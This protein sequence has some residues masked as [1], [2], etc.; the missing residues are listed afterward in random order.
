MDQSVIDGITED[1]LRGV[2]IT[3]ILERWKVSRTTFYKVLASEGISVRKYS[4]DAVSARIR[5]E[6]EIVEM[7]APVVGYKTERVLL[8]GVSGSGEGRVVE[9]QVA[10]RDPLKGITLARIAKE[11]GC[12]VSTVKLVV[13][14]HGLKGRHELKREQVWLRKVGLEAQAVMR[15]RGATLHDEDGEILFSKIGKDI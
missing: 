15:G 6:E 4:G 8:S 2:L 11:A 13:G 1:Y 7:Y 10:I 9:I 3:E 14:R 5:M 12:A